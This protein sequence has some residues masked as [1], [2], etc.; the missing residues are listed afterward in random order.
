[1]MFCI[2]ITVRKNSLKSPKP[3]TSATSQIHTTLCR[4]HPTIFWD[5]FSFG[6]VLLEA[7]ADIP[8]LIPSFLLPDRCLRLREAAQMIGGDIFSGNDLFRCA[9]TEYTNAVNSA[10]QLVRIG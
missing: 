3:R 8:V 9:I 6:L 4:T 1:M 5:C 7:V 2:F 10:D